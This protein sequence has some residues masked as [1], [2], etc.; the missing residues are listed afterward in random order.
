MDLETLTKVELVNVGITC[1]FVFT[2]AKVIIL[3]QK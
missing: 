3:K 1:L 2:S